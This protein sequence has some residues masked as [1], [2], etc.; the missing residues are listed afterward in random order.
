[1]PLLLVSGAEYPLAP[2]EKTRAILKAR[3]DARHVELPGVGHYPM[4]EDPA[5][6]AKVVK[7]FLAR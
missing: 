1:M 4:L 5:A 6:F 3:A 2:P 7:E